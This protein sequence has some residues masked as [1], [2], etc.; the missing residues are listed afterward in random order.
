MKKIIGLVIGISLVMSMSISAFATQTD[1]KTVNEIYADVYAEV[2]ETVYENVTDDYSAYSYLVKNDCYEIVDGLVALTELQLSSSE[3]IVIND[4]V[5]S[6][7]TLL[8]L[9]AVTI[10]ESLEISEKAAP[11]TQT[12]VNS[13][14][15]ILDLM[16]ETR[17]HAAQ[18]LAVYDNALFGTKHIVAGSYFAERV[19]GGGIWDYKVYLG[20]STLY[21][22]PE[23]QAY[24]TGETIGNFHYGYVGSTIFGPTT[25]KTAA[26]AVQISSNTSD[27]SYWDSYFDDPRDIADIEWGI[28]VYN[29]EN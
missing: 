7:N 5:D 1:E 29:A 13:R 10:N 9:D 19:K 6:L 4:F 3:E 21:Y 2:S 17:S 23:L 11:M 12:T 16:D 26:G 27:L 8:E 25:L 14:A 15:M 24:M 22:E 18:V 28:D 20:T